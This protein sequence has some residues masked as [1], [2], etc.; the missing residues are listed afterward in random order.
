MEFRF[1]AGNAA[2]AIRQCNRRIDKLPHRAPRVQ[3]VCKERV[4]MMQGMSPRRVES[5]HRRAG[6]WP[7]RIVIHGVFPAC[8]LL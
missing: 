3:N 5:F 6:G 1:E 2:A 7:H 8:S 4:G